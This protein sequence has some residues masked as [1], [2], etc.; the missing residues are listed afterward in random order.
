MRLEVN[1]KE[2]N[3]KK[4]KTTHT[5]RLLNPMLLNNQR[6]AEVVKE[7][8]KTYLEKNA[9]ENLVIWNL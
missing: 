7:Q 6:I 8:S 5:Q 1:Y 4:K 2:N 3:N 9:D